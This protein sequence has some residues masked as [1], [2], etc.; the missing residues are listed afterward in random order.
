MSGARRTVAVDALIALLLFLSVGA[1]AG[2]G[3]LLAA[4]DGSALGLPLALLAGT[5][6][7]D[8]FAPGVLLFTFLGIY[9]AVVCFALWRRPNWQWP[10]TLN[11]CRRLHWAWAAGWSV[12]VVL[13]VWILSQMALLG[14]CYALQYLY[15]AWGIL[16]LIVAVVP[17]V[18]GHY[19]RARVPSRDDPAR[20]T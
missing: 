9:P 7:P 3:A 17:A 18:R 1:L 15:L 12:G 20:S 14:C 13:I 11:P 2:G 16:V 10:D 19:R 8:Y 4:P 6:F 5:P